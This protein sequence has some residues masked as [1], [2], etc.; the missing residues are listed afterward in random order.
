MSTKVSLYLVLIAIAFGFMAYRWSVASRILHSKGYRTASR[1]LMILALGLLAISFHVPY[2]PAFLVLLGF[3]L[4][5]WG[6]GVLGTSE[7][8]IYLSVVTRGRPHEWWLGPSKPLEARRR[9]SLKRETRKPGWRGAGLFWGLFI[10]GY[11]V[12]YIFFY[13]SHVLGWPLIAVGLAFL[14]Q[15][16]FKYR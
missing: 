10:A 11:G 12:V 2:A 14:I 15:G 6:R 7:R 3:L 8:G 4:V 9:A 1:G 5:M 16:A 13:E